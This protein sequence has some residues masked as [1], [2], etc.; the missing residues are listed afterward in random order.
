MP[1]ELDEFDV[2]ILSILQRNAKISNVTLAAEVGLSPSPCLARVKAL[3]ESGLIK[4]H[5]TLL[6][7]VLVGLNLNVFIHV[8]MTR[9]SDKVLA[10]FATA[11]RGWREVLECHLMTGDSDYLLRLVVRDVDHLRTFVLDR[12]TPFDGI[13]SIRSSIAL[14]QIKYETALPI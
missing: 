3:T 1:M 2:K 5:V 13:A 6:D 10:A 8:T 14:D 7:P 9:Q 4:R 12:L 11:V